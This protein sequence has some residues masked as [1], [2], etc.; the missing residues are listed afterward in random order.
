ML[1]ATVASKPEH[2]LE[3]LA[4]TLLRLFINIK[5]INYI[6]AINR[7]GGGTMPGRDLIELYCLVVTM[8]IT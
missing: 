2:D 5:I 7:A 8:V 1:P 3:K 4:W 6:D